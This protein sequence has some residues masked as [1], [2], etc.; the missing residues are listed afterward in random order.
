R[1]AILADNLDF[2]A[3]PTVSNSFGQ[4]TA[5]LVEDEWISLGKR[6]ECSGLWADMADLD[7]FRA[8]SVGRHSSRNDWSSDSSCA[9]QL[10]HIATAPQFVS[11]ILSAHC[12]LSQTSFAAREPA[13]WNESIEGSLAKSISDHY[14]TMSSCL[15]ETWSLLVILV[16]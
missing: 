1:L 12:L 13:R 16:E 5:N 7:Y 6:G 2:V 14:F 10:Y 11:R 8:S 3:F 15:G 4:H 9:Q